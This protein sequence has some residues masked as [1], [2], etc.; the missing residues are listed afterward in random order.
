MKHHIS[1]SN[2]FRAVTTATLAEFNPTKERSAMNLRNAVVRLLF[3]LVLLVLSSCS[4]LRDPVPTNSATTISNVHPDGWADTLN[5]SDDDFHGRFFIQAS[6]WNLGNCQDCHGQ[7]YAGGISNS[8]CLPC[9]SDTPEDCNVCH[10]TGSSNPLGPPAPDL[11]DNT[12]TS[13][14]GVGQHTLHLE[15]GDFSAGFDCAVCH[16][17]PSSL[18]AAGHLGTD[19]RAE[20]AFTG[21]A[22]ADSAAP[23]YN[24]GSLSC[25][26]SYCHGNWSMH[27]AQA[28]PEFLGFYA[29]SAMEGNAVAP[30]W[31]DAATGECGSCHDLPPRGHFG[32]MQLQIS[33]CASCHGIVVDGSGNII[34]KTK[35]VNGKVNVNIGGQELEYDIF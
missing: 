28:R 4:E 31:T 11:A 8:S 35:H 3:V 9:H 17:V 22:L 24:S 32:H 5:V 29:A 7:N 1:A 23:A 33:A 26:N 13:A 6:N 25:A 21:L 27:S 30:G 12:A 16:V 19:A 34:D 18:N 14:R 20:L 10:G 15:G 2:V